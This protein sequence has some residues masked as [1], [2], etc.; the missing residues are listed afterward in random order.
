MN[1]KPFYAKTKADLKKIIKFR[2]NLRHSIFP[3]PFVLNYKKKIIIGA[4]IGVHRGYNALSILKHLNVE[5]IY[6]VDY[7][8][9][10]DKNFIFA[11]KYLK[12]YKKKI[13]WINMNFKNESLKNLIKEKLDFAYFDAGKSYLDTKSYFNIFKKI[14]KKNGYFCGHDFNNGYQKKH[15]PLVNAVIE[16]SIRE[17]NAFVSPTLMIQRRLIGCRDFEFSSS[18]SSS[19]L[20]RLLLRGCCDARLRGHWCD[21]ART[22]M[23]DSTLV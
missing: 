2:S 21:V 8:S 6:L 16:F 3:R 5:R 10:K 15:S 11:Q 22:N 13:V 7:Y 23:I 19:G 1:F 17:N 18:F 4:E 9:T 14:L 12:K 20:R